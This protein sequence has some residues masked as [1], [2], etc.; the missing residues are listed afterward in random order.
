M[1]YN[2]FIRYGN[3]IE[4]YTYGRDLQISRETQ[5][6]HPCRA[7]RASVDDDRKDTLSPAEFEGKRKDNAMRAQLA[8]RRLVL[9][10]LEGPEHPL[11]VTCTYRDNQTDIRV[12]YRDFGAFIQTLRYR[13]GPQF[14]YIA[15]PE[16]QKRGAVHFHALVWGLPS[17][18]FD[19]ERDTRLL[20]GL[21][22][23]GFLYLKQTDGNERLSG[24]LAKYMAKS[25][26]DYRLMNQKAYVC[27]RN[28]KRPQIQ[29]GISNFG[30]DVLL[31]EFGVTTPESDK[32]YD[33]H[34]LGKARHRIYIFS[35]ENPPKNLS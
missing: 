8:F 13:F 28:L 10:N 33:T 21:W 24:Y 29:G 22:K 9:A 6:K 12:G 30:M 14:R 23:Q 32:S 4:T 11:L 15:V 34:W 25:F 3:I 2:K 19:T 5:R 7:I 16:F 26:V 17:S 27:S 35:T 18:V 1:G 20:A 31:E